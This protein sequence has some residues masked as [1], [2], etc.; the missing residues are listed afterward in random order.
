MDIKASEKRRAGEAACAFIRDGMTVGLGTGSTVHFTILKIAE[1]IKNEGLKIRAVS[2]SKRTTELAEAHGIPIRSID[3]V[4][5][6][7]VTIDGCD[8]FDPSLRGIKGGGGALL[9][10]KIVARAS[11]VN[12]WVA[13]HSKRVEQLGAFPL[14]VEVLPFGHT[15]VMKTMASEGLKP[16][17]RKTP[18]G[19]PYI[20]D[21][22]HY[23]V[24]LHIGKIA[25][26]EELAAWLNGIPGVIE[27]GLFLGIADKVLV[28]EGDNVVTYER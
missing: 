11:R 7:D 15:H 21:S 6:I 1:R 9:F 19:S 26:P 17:L 18:D 3:D 22:G 10:E 25:R 24:D 2:T 4:P 23:I 12:I 16:A 14:P 5:E 20:T 27:N 8:E 28:A 13:D